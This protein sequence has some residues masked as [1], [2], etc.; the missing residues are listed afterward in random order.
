MLH[1][2][3]VAVSSITL[4]FAGMTFWSVGDLPGGDPN[5]AF[6]G[7]IVYA[8]WVLAILGSHEMG[9]YLAC[10]Y[11]RIPAT[12]PFFIPGIPPIGSFGA[13]IRIRGAIPDRRALFDVA[14]AGP[15]A[16]FLVALPALA[17]GLG[18]SEPFDPG[19]TAEAGTVLRFGRPFAAALL[20][21]FLLGESTE[22]T[23]N[24]TY[25]AGWVGMLVTSLNLFPVGQL[26]GGHVVFAIS[27]RVHR[28][29]SRVTPIVLLVAVV[30]QSVVQRVPPAYLVW[31][32]IL[33]WMRD[34]HPPLLDD[35][36]PLG[37]GRKI[38]ALAL[39]AIFVLSFVFVP[40]RVIA[41]AP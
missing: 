35:L 34:R 9:H 23:V 26:D 31:I 28:L 4:F 25:G 12:L 5:A 13:V 38:V 10:R 41:L 18:L 32:A 3:L 16:G 15:I 17:I 6:R 2:L 7:G 21:P 8:I 39:A 33:L 24:A 1:L 22:I 37:R 14:A 29:V 19:P 11:Y 27:R 30:V 40:I 36:R 20:R